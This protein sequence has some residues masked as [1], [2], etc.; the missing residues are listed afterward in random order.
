M[1]QWLYVSH[2]DPVVATAELCHRVNSWRRDVEACN[3][4]EATSPFAY[5][6]VPPADQT[7]PRNARRQKPYARP[8]DPHHRVPQT[9]LELEPAPFLD[10]RQI[11]AVPEVARDTGGVSRSPSMAASVALDLPHPEYNPLVRLL[12]HFSHYQKLFFLLIYHI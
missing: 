1:D 10:S 8:P 7:R 9:D 2:D 5:E 3:S 11:R 6:V 4:L 12:F